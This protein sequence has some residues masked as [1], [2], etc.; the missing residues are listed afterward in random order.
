MYRHRPHLL[1]LSEYVPHSSEQDIQVTLLSPPPEK[2]IML[3]KDLEEEE[4]ILSEVLA[5]P[6]VH[7]SATADGMIT[8]LSEKTHHIVWA[9][10]LRPREVLRL[11]YKYR[12]LWPENQEVYIN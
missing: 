8:F 4:A 10:W 2:V 5:H 1:V 9:K 7:G 11:N 3:S 6:A 12:I